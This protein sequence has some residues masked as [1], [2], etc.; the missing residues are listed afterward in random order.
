[1][2][3]EAASSA[4]ANGSISS[5]DDDHCLSLGS[6]SLY[7]RIESGSQLC[8]G[9]QPL[10]AIDSMPRGVLSEPMFLCYVKQGDFVLEENDSI[11]KVVG[12]ANQK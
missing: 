11:D 1:M 9:Q 3:L 5:D 4:S 6:L 8:E 7:L 2:V 12:V 10:Y